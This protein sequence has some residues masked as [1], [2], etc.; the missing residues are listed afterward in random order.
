MCTKDKIA[1]ASIYVFHTDTINMFKK[2]HQ[3][4]LFSVFLQIAYYTILIHKS[5]IE[6]FAVG[7]KLTSTISFLII[8]IPP[9]VYREP[10]LI[11][12][13]NMM[14]SSAV[15]YLWK[16][17]T[18]TLSICTNNKLKLEKVCTTTSRTTPSSRQFP[19]IEMPRLLENINA[20]Q[21]CQRGL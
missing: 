2:P 3:N 19:E 5:E 14:P 9:R 8:I 17:Y 1:N 21:A 7:Q 15:A 18:K 10:S 16:A 13:I 11:F 6:T 4:A 12:L 20:L